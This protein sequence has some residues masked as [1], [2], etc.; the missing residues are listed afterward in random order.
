[1]VFIQKEI[2]L[3]FSNIDQKIRSCI[4]SMWMALPNDSSVDDLETQLNRMVTRAID[5]FREDLNELS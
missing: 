3:L 5:D 2:A 4:Q 1:M